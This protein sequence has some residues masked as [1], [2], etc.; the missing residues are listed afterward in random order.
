MQ[1]A[2]RLATPAELPAAPY[3]AD[4]RAK[5]WSFELQYERIEQSDTWA[6]TPADLRP[7]LLMLWLTAWR[8]APCGSL[9]TDDELIA[10]RIGMPTRQFQAHRDLLMRGW[11]LHG[12]GRLYHPTIIEQVNTML[13]KRMTEA[14]RKSAWRAQKLADAEKNQALAG[15]VPRDSGG[16]PPSLTTPP[17]PPPPEIQKTSPPLRYGEAPDKPVATRK[18]RPA[19]VARPEGVSEQTWSDWLQLRA[20]HKA[21]VTVTV[22]SA[23]VREAGKA[24]MS[25]E[26]FLVLWCARGSRGLFAEWLKPDEL[27]RAAPQPAA[28]S[29]AERASRAARDDVDRL[30]GR[31]GVI[32]VT[33]SRLEIPHA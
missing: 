16:S 8:Q 13:R 27:R 11:R 23:A 6:L 12:D 19:D 20:G 24:G 7:W 2:L 25:L 21:K 15:N 33:P 10:A 32:D 30:T 22:L 5:G 28:M 4:T 17:P 26:D 3:P 29:F 18:P 9:P 31:R 1:T 14:E